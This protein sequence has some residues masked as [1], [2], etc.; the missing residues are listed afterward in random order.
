MEYIHALTHAGLDAGV[1][2]VVEWL[3]LIV[4]RPDGSLYDQAFVCI[5]LLPQGP[6]PARGAEALLVCGYGG[7]PDRRGGG[8]AWRWA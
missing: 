5:F 4:R 3:F 7:G 1:Y 2:R 8:A 6:G